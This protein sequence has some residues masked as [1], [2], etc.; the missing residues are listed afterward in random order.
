[1]IP[2]AEPRRPLLQPW[3]PTAT[4]AG[5]VGGGGPGRAAREFLGVPVPAPHHQDSARTLTRS[6][7]GWVLASHQRGPDGVGP[8][9]RTGWEAGR[10]VLADWRQK[11]HAGKLP[12]EADS[13]VVFKC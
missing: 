8:L 7:Q 10:T 12:S 3:E 1:M 11:L 6:P 13:S 5:T 4:T 2:P 9:L